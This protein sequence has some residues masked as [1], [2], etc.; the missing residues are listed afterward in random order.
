MTSL[1]H[2]KACPASLTHRHVGLAAA[3]RVLG[4]DA[5]PRLA[6]LFAHGAFAPRPQSQHA[7][8]APGEQVDALRRVE[9]GVVSVVI[10]VGRDE[11]RVAAER[12][13][14]GGPPPL[15]ALVVDANGERAVR[16][17][18]PAQAQHA[19]RRDVV[20][21]DVD[22]A[23][24]LGLP[25][26]SGKRRGAALADAVLRQHDARDVLQLAEVQRDGAH[27]AVADAVAAQV[28]TAQV[29]KRE[30]L[31]AEHVHRLVRQPIAGHVEPLE[32]RHVGEV[33]HHSHQAQVANVV[34]GQAQVA[35]RQAHEVFG[36]NVDAIVSDGGVGHVE[37]GQ[38]RRLHD[39]PLQPL[40]AVRPD[41]VVA[42]VQHLQTVVGHGVERVGQHGDAVGAQAHV[43]D[44]QPVDV[45]AGAYQI[46]DGA[47]AVGEARRADGHVRVVDR[48]VEREV[49]EQ[50]R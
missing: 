15:A 26:V 11:G 18:G 25:H 27:A 41:R 31:L 20:K 46:A 40:H 42:E 45:A 9:Q 6:V 8:L 24:R 33:T 47:E 39:E 35:Q 5:V 50:L 17:G 44:V 7:V 29:R 13:V 49:V 19:R 32:R 2:S 10:V 36:Q 43:R 34:V 38:H 37:V 14:G 23:Q 30:D 4:E 22:E 3:A 1:G 12:H 16:V 28:E 21:T 48:L